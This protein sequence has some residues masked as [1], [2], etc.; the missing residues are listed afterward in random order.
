MCPCLVCVFI[1]CGVVAVGAARAVFRRKLLGIVVVPLRERRGRERLGRGEEVE[2]VQGAA[3]RESPDSLPVAPCGGE[4][5]LHG[6][7]ESP[8]GA[9]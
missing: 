4:G 9:D 1:E 5:R 2:M 8:S 3:Y 7:E 6:G